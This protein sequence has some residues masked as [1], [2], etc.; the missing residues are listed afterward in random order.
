MNLYV[1]SNICTRTSLK[2]PGRRSR[3]RLRR[4]GV[5]L[6][7]DDLTAIEGS[8]TKFVGILQ[9]RYGYDKVKAEKEYS[10]F[11]AHHKKAA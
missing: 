11:M 6:T 10:D 8:A 3:V 5:K 9:K 4:N 7:D 1:R 2:G